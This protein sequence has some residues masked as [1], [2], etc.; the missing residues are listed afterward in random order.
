MLRAQGKVIYI[1][2]SNFAGWHIAQAQEAAARHGALG[3]VSEQSLY[4]LAVRAVELEVLPACQGYGLGADPGGRRSTAA[5][6]AGVLRKEPGAGSRSSARGCRAR[7]PNRA[8]RPSQAYEA[9]CAELGEDPAMWAWPG[10]C[11]SPR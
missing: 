9:F 8:A 2:S 7:G 1:G 11:T 6:S 5:C 3:L 4:N 10:C